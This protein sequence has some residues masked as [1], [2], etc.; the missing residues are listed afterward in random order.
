MIQKIL[1]YLK[2]LI[3]IDLDSMVLESSENESNVYQKYGVA[4]AAGTAVALFSL[5]IMAFLIATGEVQLDEIK[6]RKIV[7][8][9]MPQRDPE[10]FDSVE[11]P[12]EA[13]P[14][15]EQTPPDVDIENIDDVL[16]D[17]LNLNFRFKA[18]RQGVFADGS[19]VP[20]FQVPPQYPR[21]AMER[22]IEGCVLLEL[23]LIHISEPTRQP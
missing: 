19:Y 5:F 18:K 6:T 12:E 2:K 11:R 3:P 10:L 4:A 9:V 1:N 22:G 21:R 16:D 13:E 7:D 23:S 20:I 14:E 17:A 15:P 8:I